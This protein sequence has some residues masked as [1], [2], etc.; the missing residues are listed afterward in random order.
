MLIISLKR[1]F[2]L[3][4]VELADGY[5]PPYF[6]NDFPTNPLEN[7]FR[8]DVSEANR[9]SIQKHEVNSN[10]EQEKFIHWQSWL[11]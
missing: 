10:L 8:R 7:C 9:N 5:N 3:E 6:H 2:R 1:D 11:P 4:A